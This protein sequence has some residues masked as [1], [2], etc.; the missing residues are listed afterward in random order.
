MLSELA[1][2]VGDGAGGAYMVRVVVVYTHIR[3][4]ADARRLPHL[5]R[6]P[7]LPGK[8]MRAFCGVIL[9]HIVLVHIDRLAR[10]ALLSNARAC[11]VVAICRR[12]RSVNRF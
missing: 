6:N 5:R 2:I 3:H 11:I 4:G 8:D 10:I 7:R 1:V 9:H 12:I